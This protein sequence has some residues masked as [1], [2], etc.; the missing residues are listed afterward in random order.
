MRLYHVRHA[1]TAWN[2]LEL[3]QGHT[4]VELDETGREQAE[5][6]ARAFVSVDLAKV[7][8]SDLRRSADC[9][10]GI[11]D[12]SGAELI[13]DPRLRERKMGEWEGLPYGEFN[14]RFRGAAVA[15][16]PYLMKTVPPGGESL[17]DVWAR[18]EPLRRELEKVKGTCVVVTHGGTC[19]LFLAQL[20]KANIETAR[21]FRFAN[22]GITELERRQDGLFNLVRYNDARHLSGKANLSGSLDGVSR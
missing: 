10:R 20:L 18:I 11:A 15:D 21:S 6:L 4:D 7:W 8:S 13:L 9:A 14:R 12:H 22:A 19:S 17:Y 5:L 1:Q 2:A 16:D 3:A